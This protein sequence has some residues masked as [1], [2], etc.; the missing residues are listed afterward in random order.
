MIKMDDTDKKAG[1]NWISGGERSL[2]SCGAFA[3]SQALLI[4]AESKILCLESEVSSLRQHLNE[5]K[6]RN[7]SSCSRVQA[8]DTHQVLQER[9]HKASTRNS[10]AFL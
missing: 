8:E 4:A 1:V 6:I 7:G 9:C 3:K 10:S 2:R 5:E